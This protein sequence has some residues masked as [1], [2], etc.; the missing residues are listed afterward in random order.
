[1][2]GPNHHKL[3]RESKKITRG[4]DNMNEYRIYHSSSEYG[5]AIGKPKV[6]KA[7][8]I[9]HLRARL[10]NEIEADMRFM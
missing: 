6:V 7:K 1:M 4:R 8:D 2:R 3:V 10:I 5:H 9:D